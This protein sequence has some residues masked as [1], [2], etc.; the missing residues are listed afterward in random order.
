MLLSR[1]SLQNIPL[2]FKKESTRPR[3]GILYKVRRECKHRPGIWG[4]RSF[5][6]VGNSRPR[7]GTALT[8]VFGY[9]FALP[10]RQHFSRSTVTEFI[11]ANYSF[12]SFRTIKE[13]FIRRHDSRSPGDRSRSRSGAL[14]CVS[15]APV[16]DSITGKYPRMRHLLSLTQNRVAPGAPEAA[17]ASTLT[18]TGRIRFKPGYSRMWRKS[19]TALKYVWGLTFRYQHPL[20]RFLVKF[21]KMKRISLMQLYELRLG[22]VLTYL[23]FSPDTSTSSLF[24]EH[25]LV[26]LNGRACFNPDILL[27]PNDLVQMAVTSKYYI[28]RRLLDIS[29]KKKAARLGAFMAV[30]KKKI[31]SPVST[32]MTTRFPKWLL[33]LLF[34]SSDIPKYF[35]ADFFTLTAHCLYRPYC[36]QDFSAVTLELHKYD[37]LKLYNWKYI[38]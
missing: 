8:S 13:Y 30:K 26:F 9:F 16:R 24:C 17:P 32:L 23:H 10:V 27:A 37:V 15:P 25:N 7:A 36:F 2:L 19:R 29:Q 34:Y 35:E 11:V 4:R 31:F 20:T 22:N 12:T 14:L 21:F 3:A 28:V 6:G 1:K 38:T 33:A 18:G 5:A